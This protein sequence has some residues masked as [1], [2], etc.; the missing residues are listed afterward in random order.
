VAE[1][2]EALTGAGLEPITSLGQRESETKVELMPEV[3]EEEDH[4]V[5]HIA[6]LP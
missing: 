1:V 3:S 6:R 2:H 4:K 5:I